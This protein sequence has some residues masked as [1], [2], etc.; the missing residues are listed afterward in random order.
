LNLSRTIPAET[1]TVIHC[2]A[3][4][5]AGRAGELL[6]A[7]SDWTT[8]GGSGVPRIVEVWGLPWSRLL[9][10]CLI[11]AAAGGGPL[12]VMSLPAA[13]GLVA[14]L[15][16]RGVIVRFRQARQSVVDDAELRAVSQGWPLH[17]V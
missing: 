5:D 2:G 17:H 7:A 8:A 16:A 6:D 9:A 1:F 11:T 15:K 12:N 4:I 13:D 3:E 10:G 14:D